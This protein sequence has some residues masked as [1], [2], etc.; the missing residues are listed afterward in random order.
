LSLAVEGGRTQ[1]VA[2]FLLFASRT[3]AIC[4]VLAGIGVGFLQMTAGSAF[5]C[6]DSCVTREFMFSYLGPSTVQ[7]LLPCVVLKLLA[8]VA[9]VAYCL[10]TGQARRVVMP[11]LFLLVGGLLGVAGLDAL[12]QHAQT[13]LPVGEGDILIAGPAESFR[14]L[15]GLAILLVAGTWSGVLA[16]LQWRR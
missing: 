12:L 5:V 4:A 8:L 14:A 2:E 10:A 1:R 16:Y 15:W 13:T 11:I 7:T 9:F 3:L 6:F